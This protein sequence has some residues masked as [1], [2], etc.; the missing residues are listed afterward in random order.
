[1]VHP[2][3]TLVV[4]FNDPFMMTLQP[5]RPEKGKFS[6]DEKIF[7][8]THLPAYEVLCRDLEQQATGPRGTGHVKGSKKAWVISQ[9][10][11]KFVERFSS[12]QDGGPQL[13]SLQV[14]SCIF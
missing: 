9:V 13:Q 4:P 2:S 6:N 11:P 12:N 8:K 7:L 1:M 5:K 3:S 10:F 14:V